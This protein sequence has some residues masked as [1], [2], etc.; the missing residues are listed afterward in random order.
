MDTLFFRT[1]EP[2]TGSFDIFL[3]VMD[4]PASLS[5]AVVPWSSLG[6]EY[7]TRVG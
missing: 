4:M 7:G 2:R 6:E 3:I 5:G 1:S